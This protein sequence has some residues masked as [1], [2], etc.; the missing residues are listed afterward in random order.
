MKHPETRGAKPHP[1][2]PTEIMKDLAVTKKEKVYNILMAG[3]IY[4]L[5]CFLVGDI[6]IF[7]VHIARYG[8]QAPEMFGWW[9]TFLLVGFT[10]FLMS[11]GGL[12][13]V[14]IYAW[15]HRGTFKSLIGFSIVCGSI[16]VA[17]VAVMLVFDLEDVCPI[18]L[19]GPIIITILCILAS[20]G[21][22]KFSHKVSKGQNDDN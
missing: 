13:V 15:L 6:T 8:V 18:F 14:M 19:I 4:V 21:M 1:T 9:G 5:F 3:V 2:K 12:L 10:S 17:V 20:Y 22:T 11:L 7:A 16:S